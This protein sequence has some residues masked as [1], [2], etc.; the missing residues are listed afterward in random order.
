MDMMLFSHKRFI[1]PFG[2][3]MSRVEEILRRWRLEIK[4]VELLSMITIIHLT[5]LN[6]YLVIGVHHHEN[7]F[8]AVLQF[9]NVLA[10]MAT[11]L[12]W[13]WEANLFTSG[14][15]DRCVFSCERRIYLSWDVKGKLG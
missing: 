10:H 6:M 7:T 14:S 5:I 1:S 15:R 2:S 8:P 12:V 3:L 11:S 4:H 13:V 9:E